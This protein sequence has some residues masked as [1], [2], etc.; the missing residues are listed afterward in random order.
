MVKWAATS[1]LQACASRARDLLPAQHLG[2]PWA[3]GADEDNGNRPLTA[4]EVKQLLVPLV[5]LRQACCHPQ[6]RVL[7]S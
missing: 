3:V 5:R 1:L 2:G 6:A 7:R 4:R